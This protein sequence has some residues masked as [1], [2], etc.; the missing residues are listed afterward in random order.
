MRDTLFIGHA[1]PQDNDFTIWLYSKLELEGY[2]VWCDL[3]CLHG[4]ESDFWDEIQTTIRN[5]ACKYLLVLSQN[6]FRKDGVKDEFEYARSIEREF[7]LRDF[8]I[9]LRI[10]SVPFNE[11]IGLNRRNILDFRSSWIPGLRSLFHKLTKDRIPRSTDLVPSISDW[12]LKE[13]LYKNSELYNGEE[14]HYSNWWQIESLPESIYVFQYMN[15]SQAQAIIE[16]DADYPVI[17][18]GNCLISFERNIKK[19]S[20]KNDNIEINPLGIQSLSTKNILSGDVSGDFPTQTDSENFLKRLLKKAFKN[21][22]YE[23]GLSKKE[24]SNDQCFFYR[25]NTL[26]SNW[27]IAKYPNKDRRKKLVGKYHNKYL[28]HLAVSTRVMLAPFLCY[29]L[30]THILFS[31]DGFNIWEDDTRLHSA[32]RSKGKK[33]FNEE[34]RDRLMAFINSLANGKDKIRMKLANNFVLE[35][36]LVTKKFYSDIGYHEPDTKERLNILYDGDQSLYED[37]ELDGKSED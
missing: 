4:G 18:H 15:E 10:D 16:E 2:R 26:K 32:R 24:L 8:I 37:D 21:L 14:L 29:S 6:S 17:K 11:R 31:D 33:W 9:P 3:E 20:R 19:I 13:H 34:W 30:K 36:P 28:W 5:N 7:K 22:V 23:K 27:A 35:M 1:N 12:I 25:H